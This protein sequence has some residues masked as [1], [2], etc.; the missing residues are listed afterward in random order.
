MLEDMVHTVLRIYVSVPS[1][2]AMAVV[3]DN[4]ILILVGFFFFCFCTPSNVPLQVL[5]L[6]FHI[7]IPLITGLLSRTVHTKALSDV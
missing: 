5:F 3:C 2:D 1:E 6:D 4:Y 7:F